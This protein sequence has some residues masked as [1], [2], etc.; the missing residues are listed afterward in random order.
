MKAG[1]NVKRRDAG[2]AIQTTCHSEE[3]SRNELITMGKNHIENQKDRDETRDT[4]TK[5]R[6]N[7]KTESAQEKK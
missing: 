2:D 4:S 5:S 1:G 7:D 3:Q 6:K